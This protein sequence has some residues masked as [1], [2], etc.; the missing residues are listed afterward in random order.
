MNEKENSNTGI[1]LKTSESTYMT[2][3]QRNPEH[4]KKQTK[5]EG[6][7]ILKFYVRLAGLKM[8]STKQTSR[9]GDY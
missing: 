4:I 9:W 3:E 2:T 1:E 8:A 7:L 5:M 6:P